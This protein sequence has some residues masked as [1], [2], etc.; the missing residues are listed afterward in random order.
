MFVPS[1]E[2]R[3]YSGQVL[4]KTLEYLTTQ[5]LVPGVNALDIN[6]KADEFIRSHGCTPTFLG[7][8]GFSG[9]LCIS[10]NEEVVHGVP[11][12]ER[13]IKEGDIVS[14]DCGVTFKGAITDAARTVAVGEVPED[15][16]KLL[17]VTEESLLKGI[18][19]LV[20]GAV[21]G[22]VS[23]QI[24][25]H[26]ERQ[27]FVV[28]LDFCGHGIDHRLHA[29]PQIPNYGPPGKGRPFIVGN[30]YAIEP[31]VYT[32]RVPVKLLNDGW[33]VVTKDNSLSAHFEDTVLLESTGPRILTRL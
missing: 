1:L 23:Y 32:K 31:V 28:S 18:A 4:A 21:I 15:T 24:Q 19:V 12:R 2:D 25:K 6:N 22:D 27:G 9:S 8:S 30:C 20:P 33:T 3:I 16:K 10:V 5:V 17:Q 11:K 14:L 29:D 26:V 7:Y 13:V